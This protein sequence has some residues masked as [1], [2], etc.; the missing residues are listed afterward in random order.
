MRTLTRI[1][2]TTYCFGQ[3]AEGIKTSSFSLFLLFYYNQVLG[4][5]GWMCS[6]ALA[7]AMVV[8][9]ITDPMM[10][11][12]SDGWKSRLGRRHP[13]MYISAVPLAV[14]FYAVF[15]PPVALLADNR[16]ALLFAWFAGM[17]VLT[18]VAFTLYHVPH[19][20]LGAEL[21]NDHL[22]RTTLVAFRHLFGALA[23]IVVFAVGFLVFFAATPEF[24]NGQL[25]R[26]AYSPFTAFLAALMVLSVLTMAFGTQR[27]AVALNQPTVSEVSLRNV[28]RDM[29]DA[30]RN[31]SFRVLVTGFIIISVPIGVGLALALYLNTY[32]WQVN[33]THMTVILV[34]GPLAALIGYSFAPLLARY[35]E[36]RQALIWGATGW[37][38]FTAA[39]IVLHY[40][41]LFPTP[42][43][44]GCTVGLTVSQLLAGIVVSQL[45]V[46]VGSMLGDVTDEHELNTHRRQEG[47]FFGAYIF[48]VKATAGM[49]AAFSGVVLDLITWPT[50]DHIKTAA[51][52]P[53]ET[54]FYLSMIAGPGLALGVAPA[55]WI[56]LRYPLNRARHDAIVKELGER[57][58]AEAA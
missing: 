20:A 5:P 24:E 55:V 36:K 4:L 22:E 40:A 58:A 53:S 26:E 57:H 43:T 38:F 39:P 27:A 1:T 13:F 6:V 51:D 17:T 29:M 44:L 54:L 2:K 49:G 52:V 42:G 41:G 46:A 32:F 25:N 56:F 30:M 45:I 47:A 28:F 9:A 48:I 33:P 3:L 37:V 50:G 23:Y 34:A 21:T 15:N 35:I 10:G 12:L 16:E 14:C 7:L 18:R 8:D 11:S 31:R 19:L